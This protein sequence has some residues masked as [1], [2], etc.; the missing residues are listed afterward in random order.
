MLDS[1]NSQHEKHHKAIEKGIDYSD[2]IDQ[3]AESVFR[4]WAENGSISEAI[5]CACGSFRKEGELN[6]LECLLGTGDFWSY[7]KDSTCFFESKEVIE[8]AVELAGGR[9]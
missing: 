3:A 9:A 6:A 2:F 8:K 4:Q 5:E 1:F 7:L